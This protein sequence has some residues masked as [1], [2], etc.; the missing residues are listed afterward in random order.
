MSSGEVDPEL[1]R[2][3]AEERAAIIEEACRVSREE[4]ERR[5][6]QLLGYRSWDEVAQAG[7]P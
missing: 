5:A 1:L 2:D 3:L 6:A 4:A 7:R